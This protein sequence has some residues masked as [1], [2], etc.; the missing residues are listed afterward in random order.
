[1][2]Q[3]A[4]GVP[5]G[6]ACNAC[7][8]PIIHDPRT[9]RFGEVTALRKVR[10]VLGV[11]AATM[12]VSLASVGAIAGPAMANSN[13]ET[14]SA[15]GDKL[16]TTVYYHS[17]GSYWFVESNS[18]TISNNLAK[19]NNLYMRLRNNGG[20]NEYWAWTSGDD[21]VGGHT[22]QLRVGENVPRTG[23]PYMK[24]NAIFDQTGSDPNCNTYADLV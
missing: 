19:K 18:A 14:C 16:S 12:A 21:I 20:A 3:M 8:T 23:S 24:T 17:N 15:G 9:G 11:T 2:R 4:G 1:M 5:S 22:Y 6:M 10:K 7:S 13:Y